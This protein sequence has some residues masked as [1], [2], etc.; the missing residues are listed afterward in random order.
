MSYKICVL[1]FL[2]GLIEDIGKDISLPILPTSIISKKFGSI[3]TWANFFHEFMKL[4]LISAVFWFSFYLHFEQTKYIFNVCAWNCQFFM[5]IWQVIIRTALVVKKII[6]SSL[7]KSVKLPFFVDFF[8]YYHRIVW[9]KY[10]F[11]LFLSK[12]GK[13]W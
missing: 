5:K 9:K 8:S 7:S 2:N 4:N 13:N 6:S 11:S 1:D 12:L 10:F 3:F